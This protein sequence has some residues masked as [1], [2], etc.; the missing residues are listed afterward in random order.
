MDGTG[1]CSF[2]FVNLWRK[3]GLIWDELNS[4]VADKL[5]G[6]DVGS[7]EVLLAFLAGL[8]VSAVVVDCNCQKCRR[9]IGASQALFWWYLDKDRKQTS[10]IA[11]AIAL[12]AAILIWR[13]SDIQG[14][15]Y[16][17]PLVKLHVMAVG[18]VS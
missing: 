8:K 7:E 2:L 10:P 6:E 16:A 17:S 4:G 1:D 18:V 9:T 15:V 5:Y 14:N 3:N 12:C 11:G 13:A